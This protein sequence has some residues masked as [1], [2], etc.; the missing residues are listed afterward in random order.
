[1]EIKGCDKCGRILPTTKLVMH[2]SSSVQDDILRDRYKCDVPYHYTY[3]CEPCEKERINNK[4]THFC[5]HKLVDYETPCKKCGQK[6]VWWNP[7]V[8]IMN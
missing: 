1:M 2:K 5:G 3:F 6:V 8:G 4:N 7:R